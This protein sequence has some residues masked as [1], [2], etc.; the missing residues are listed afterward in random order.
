MPLKV[1][2]K[3]KIIEIPKLVF[4][5]KTPDWAWAVIVSQSLIIML[6]TLLKWSK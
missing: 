5:K 6:I 1:E 3:E 4:K 2:Y